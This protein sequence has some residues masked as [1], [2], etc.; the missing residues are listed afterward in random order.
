VGPPQPSGSALSDPIFARNA[1]R[2]KVHNS[3]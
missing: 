2:A 1:A 3:L